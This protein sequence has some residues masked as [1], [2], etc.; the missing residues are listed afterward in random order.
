MDP[1]DA[2]KVLAKKE[3]WSAPGSDRLANFWWKRAESLHGGVATAFEAISSIDGKYPLWFSQGKTSLIPKPGE[4]ICD[5][6]RPIPCLNTMYKWYTSCLL[7]PTDKHLDDYVLMEGAQ[8]G[9]RVGCSGTMDNLLVDR[10]VTQDCHR[11]KRKKAYDSIGHGWLEEMMI[12]HRSP[13]WLCRTTMSLSRSWSTRI[14]VTTTNG[15]EA[16]KI[17]KV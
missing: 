2:A 9:A 6:Q 12:I 10:M 15:R 8:R 16:S 14:V 13:T 11:K 17:V 4:F 7:V 1:A 3:N 5:N